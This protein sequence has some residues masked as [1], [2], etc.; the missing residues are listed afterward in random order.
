MSRNFEM[1]QQAAVERG[2]LSIPAPEIIFPDLEQDQANPKHTESSVDHTELGLDQSAREEALKLVQRVFL[3]QTTDPLP[4]VVVF[5]GIDRGSGCSLICAE[6]ARVLA[7]NVPGPVCIVDA[8]FRSPSLA[9]LF[10]VPN[11]RGL[12]NALL[13]DDPIVGFAKR[14]RPDNFWLLSSGALASDSP[15]LLYSGHLKTRF[16][17][18]RKH[19]EY[20]LIDVSALNQYADA[21]ALGKI[22]DGLVLVLEAHST[23]RESALKGV[24][25]LQAAQ[26]RV[27]GAVLNKRTFP[28]PESLYRRL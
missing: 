16:A 15:N 3:A 7:A 11:H 23:R 17:E 28:I 12:T 21:T 2:T 24:E 8:N 14:L 5:A 27:L 20:V 25:T 9:Q 1:M 13:S 6:A 26:I 22:A 10:G 4:H 18:L 19:F